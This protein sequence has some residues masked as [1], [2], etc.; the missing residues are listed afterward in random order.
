[1]RV[2]KIVL[3]ANAVLLALNLLPAIGPLTALSYGQ[4][5]PEFGPDGVPY[6]K[7]NINPTNVPPAV[8]INPDGIVPRIEIAPLPDIEV[9]PLGCDKRTSFRTGIGQSISGPLVVTYLS[10][11]RPD[12]QISLIDGPTGASRG[13]NLGAT[14]PRIA[15]ALYLGAGQ[16]LEF[17]SD[18]L[19]SGC[20]PE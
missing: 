8:N 16:S 1:M 19:Y 5:P 9:A 20:E 6:F 7:V 15:T 3:G 14:S 17:E 13:V 18:V 12:Q 11:D 10:I 4:R 2:A